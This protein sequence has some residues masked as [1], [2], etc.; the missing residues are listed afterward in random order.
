[1]SLVTSINVV[2]DISGVKHS[3]MEHQATL[4]L[5]RLDRDE[6]HC[7]RGD[8]FADCLGI[9]VVVLL[10]FDARSYMDW[11]HQAHRM[12]ERLVFA[13]PIILNP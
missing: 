5:R 11:P 8:G 13:S 6:P 4:L 7:G 3:T 12:T 9:G 2:R 1:M 10:P